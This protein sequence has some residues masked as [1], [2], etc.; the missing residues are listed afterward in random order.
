MKLLLS[1]FSLGSKEKQ[2]SLPRAS[3]QNLIFL[4]FLIPKVLVNLHKTKG[5]KK[6]PNPLLLSSFPLQKNPIFLGEQNLPL[7]KDQKH[8]VRRRMGLCYLMVKYILT[9]PEH[10][11]SA[12]LTLVFSEPR[13]FALSLCILFI[14]SDAV[15]ARLQPLKEVLLALRK[16]FFP[17]SKTR[18]LLAQSNLF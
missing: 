15:S 3:H 1:S 10:Q 8:M 17:L 12:V 2:E 4:R 11:R 6:N 13:E 5:K 14:T 18:S 7:L 16:H 9:K